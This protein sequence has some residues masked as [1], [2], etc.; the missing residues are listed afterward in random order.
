VAEQ[1][2]ALTSRIGIHDYGEIVRIEWHPPAEPRDSLKPCLVLHFS[3]GLVQEQ[4]AVAESL[5]Y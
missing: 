2:N 1:V 4:V 3:I 5:S